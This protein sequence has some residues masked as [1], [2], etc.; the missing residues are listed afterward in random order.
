MVTPSPPLANGQKADL[1]LV[2]IF[3]TWERHP[4]AMIVAGAYSAEV[5]LATK[6]GSHSHGGLHYRQDGVT[7]HN[8]L[9]IELLPKSPQP[10][11]LKGEERMPA[12]LPLWKRGPDGFRSTQ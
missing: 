10:P 12:S 7:P 5:A 11:L 6:A 8:L 2:I 3:L 1:N 4:A 9:P